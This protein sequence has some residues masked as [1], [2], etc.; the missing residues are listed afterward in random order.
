MT[1]D[2][3]QMLL[4]D[5]RD[6][7]EMM[8]MTQASIDGAREQIFW[9]APDGRFVFV[10]NCTCS[11]LGYQRDELLAMNINMIEP[12]LP[13][14][15]TEGFDKVK[16]EGALTYATIHRRKDGTTLPVEVSVIY[17]EY[18]GKEYNILFARN[19]AERKR[20]EK[21]LRLTQYSVD[22]SPN[23][24]FWVGPDGLLT[25]ASESTCRALGYT[26]EEMLCMR[27]DDIDPTAAT[28]WG[29]H[30]ETLRVRGQLQFE[31]VHYT[32]DR[33]AIPVEVN[34]AHVEYE[35][36]EYSFVSAT[37]ISERKETEAL[38]HDEAQ[39]RRIFVEQSSDGIVVVNAQG[40]V[41]EANEAYARMLGYTLDEVRQLHIWDWDAHHTREEL[42]QLLE[43]DTASG[44]RIETI[45]RRK[46]GSPIA[47]EISTNGAIIAGQRMSFCVCRDVTERKRME[48]SLRLTQFSVDNSSAQIF[49]VGEDS[50][51]VAVNES[52][53]RQLGYTREE[54][55][56]LTIYDVDPTAPQPWSMFWQAM[57]SSQ[58]QRTFETVHATKD[59]R[60]IPVEV[61]TNYVEHDGQGYN[62]VFATDISSRKKMEEHLRLTQLSIDRARDQIF[63]ITPQGHFVY[64][65]DSTCQQLGYS[66]DELAHMTIF[67]IDPTLPRD[68]RSA[69]DELKRHGALVHEAIHVTKDGV[70]MPVEVRANYMQHDGNEYNFV[71][72]SD[73]RER[74]LMEEQ[75][76]LTQL[77]VNRAGD[78]IFWISPEGTLV[79][80][81]DSTCK[82][83]GYA[84]EELMNMTIYDI[85]PTAARP[86]RKGWDS[87]K[88]RGAA[89]T[90][91]CIAP[92]TASRCRSR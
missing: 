90:K 50:R 72:A 64:A 92:R 85:D 30:W 39:R 31:T 62:S 37:D 16:N 53:C 69:W 61:T 71:F 35:G 40:E 36:H 57:K 22:N 84:P 24:I 83:L 52:M 42:L 51:L 10:N 29:Q 86:W 75:L 18:E 7:E 48:E 32:R 60:L 79:F 19:S 6:L 4:D 26:R 81:S 14:P 3:G 28:T 87:I 67:D 15:W 41:C 77:S 76:R 44:R 66:R 1:D 70:E 46:D 8:R 89:V 38:S 13:G 43:T 80:A 21:K 63:W 73:I 25:Y 20:M 49:W 47:V 54:M 11:E 5:G 23:Q 91:R 33:R 27:I 2:Q 12:K 55:S 68:W 58:S 56:R 17:V 82:Q 65:S 78:Q 34:A 9:L 45:H 74:K 59:G 88:E